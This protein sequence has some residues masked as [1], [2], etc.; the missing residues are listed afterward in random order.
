MQQVALAAGSPQR[1][2]SV[3]ESS[4]AE[5]VGDAPLYSLRPGVTFHFFSSQA[6]CKKDGAHFNSSFHPVVVISCRWRRFDI[7]TVL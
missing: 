5:E 4:T 6:P 2:D 3:F 1:D 7:S